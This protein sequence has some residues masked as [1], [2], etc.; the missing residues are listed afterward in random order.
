VTWNLGAQAAGAKK[1]LT[2]KLRAS[3][4]GK[5]AVRA[6]AQASGTKIKSEAEAVIQVDGVPALSFE[7]ANIDNP[8]EVG[9]E[10]TY[11]IRVVNQGTC[12]LTNMKIAAVV[13]E[14]L[15]ILDVKGPTKHT[16]NGQS[17]TLEP[18]QKL[19]VKADIVIRVKAK[20]TIAGDMRCKV[21][22]LCDQLKQPVVKE[23]STVFFMP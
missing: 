6:L 3:V 7:V 12:P 4:S 11:E 23:E 19:A 2:L 13:S 1:Q 16:I 21:Q 9:K 22:L 14:G 5:I 15:S 8:A 17:I 10:V 20:G 18:V